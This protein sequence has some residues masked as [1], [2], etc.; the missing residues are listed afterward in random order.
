MDR[1]LIAIVLTALCASTQT[2]SAIDVP[3]PGATSCSGCHAMRRSA[4]TPVT[5]LVARNPADILTAM[6]EFRA[7]KRPAT[8]MDR[9]AKGFTDDEVK[10]IAA[11][12]AAQ[13]E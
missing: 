10:A 6:Q 7:G 8:V 3:P 9:I 2:A 1:I 4:G 12:Y 5:R 11:W 13:K